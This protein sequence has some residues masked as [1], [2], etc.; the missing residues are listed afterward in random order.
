MK[1]RLAI[2]KRILKDENRVICQSHY[3]C[4]L[5]LTPYERI[6]V[7]FLK[8]PSKGNSFVSS[9]WKDV[10]QEALISVPLAL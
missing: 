5:L 1:E 9:C 6:T 10:N 3:Q 4:N 8:A 2:L 7:H